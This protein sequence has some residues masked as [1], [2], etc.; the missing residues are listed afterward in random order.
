VQRVSDFGSVCEVKNVELLVPTI[1]T[2]QL[3]FYG[4]NDHSGNGHPQD[5]PTLKMCRL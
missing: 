5:V 3:I 1:Y 2:A 4:E